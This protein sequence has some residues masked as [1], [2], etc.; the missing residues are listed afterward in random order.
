[1]T[2]MLVKA[3]WAAKSD[4]VVC[5]YKEQFTFFFVHHAV[6]YRFLLTFMPVANAKLNSHQH[7]T[8]LDA[9]L[10]FRNL[11]IHDFCAAVFT[12]HTSRCMR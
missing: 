7:L 11:F 9:A 3:S 4:L 5:E 10:Q 12:L 1:M 2:V 8:E 6:C